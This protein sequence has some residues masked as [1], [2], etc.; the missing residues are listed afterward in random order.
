MI[1]VKPMIGAATGDNMI[2]EFKTDT[3]QMAIP[4]SSDKLELKYQFDILYLKN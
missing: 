4:F 1:I 2:S 3:M